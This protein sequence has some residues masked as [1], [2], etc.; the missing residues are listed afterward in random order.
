MVTSASGI[1]TV[2]VSTLYGSNWVTT[3][4]GVLAV[5]RVGVSSFGLAVG[6]S[7]FPIA[8]DVSSAYGSALVTSAAGVLAGH[9]TSMRAVVDAQIVDRLLARNIAGGSDTGR[10]VTE[11]LYFLRNRS[12]IAGTTLTVYQTDDA[13]SSWSA[14][15]S[16]AAGN[17]IV[18]VDPA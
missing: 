13:T 3:A 11:A 2:N 6:V 8:V 16:T 7:S 15:V 17:P 12:E 9:V 14:T 5:G 18:S 10:I 1:L 4:A